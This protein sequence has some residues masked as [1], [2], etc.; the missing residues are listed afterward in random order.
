MINKILEADEE[1]CVMA[2]PLR[3]KN[4][5]SDVFANAHKKK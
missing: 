4:F 2:S 3:S 1:S 5:S